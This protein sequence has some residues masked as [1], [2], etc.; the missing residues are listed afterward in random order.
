MIEK[1]VVVDDGNNYLRNA[2]WEQAKKANLRIRA[3]HTFVFDAEKNIIL[4]RRSKRLN[5]WPELW[6][7]TVGETQRQGESFEQ[8]AKRGVKEEYG[9]IVNVK[10]IA[11]FPLDMPTGRRYYGLFSCMADQPITF[12]EKEI[13]EIEKMPFS[14]IDRIMKER[15]FVPQAAE[16]LRR[17]REHIHNKE[18]NM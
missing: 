6:S 17:Y 15:L 14:D 3:T 12:D 13:S 18:V 16:M 1:V 5:P 8:C 10:A 4:H 9:I 2:T 11:E 7:L